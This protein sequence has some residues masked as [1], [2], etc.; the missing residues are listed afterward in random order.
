MASD[1]FT[2]SPNTA[3]ETHNANWDSIGQEGSTDTFLV[4]N[5]EI[6]SNQ[7]HAEGNFDSAGA[8]YTAST[9]VNFCEIEILPFNH[10]NNDI[11]VCIQATGTRRGYYAEWASLSG[12]VFG[13][14]NLIEDNGT[15]GEFLGF[16]G[17][18][19]WD[20]TVGWKTTIEMVGSDITVDIDDVEEINET[21]VNEL[22]GG[23]P[24]FFQA[25]NFADIGEYD[26]WNDGV[27]GGVAA[28]MNQLQYANLGSDLYNGALQ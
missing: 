13:G 5:F 8:R 7:C 6:Q 15:T 18:G 2:D 26:D 25:G 23:D 20:R 19:G 9:D 4:T 12:N 27:A 16:S 28:I 10:G 11:G 3:L 22:T 24:G 14:M 1:D 21:Y 17:T